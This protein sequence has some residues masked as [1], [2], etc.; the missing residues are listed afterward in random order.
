[1]KK[2]KRAD[3]I[4]C[5]D[6]THSVTQRRQSELRDTQLEEWEEVLPSPPMLSDSLRRNLTSGGVSS[7]DFER[8]SSGI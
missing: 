2:L 7:L 5:G 3:C 1:M 8:T 6:V 4:A